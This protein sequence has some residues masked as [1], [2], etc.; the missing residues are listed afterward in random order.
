MAKISADGST[1]LYS[2]YLGG[3][4]SDV[5]NGVAVDTFGDA[6]VTGTTFSPNFPVTVDAFN[7]LCGG[8]G[9]CGTTYNPQ[10][11]VVSN[12]FV[13]KLNPAGTGLIYSS[14]LGE[15]ENV[16]GQ[17]IAVDN[18]EIA[19]VT[20][21]ADPNFAPTVPIV[22]PAV[23]PPPFPIAVGIPNGTWRW[24]RCFCDQNQRDR[25]FNPILEL[26]WGRWGRYRVRYSRRRLWGCLCYGTYLFAE[27]PHCCSAPGS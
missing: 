21:Q 12:A 19:Y 3:A 14:F 23:P 1:L 6:Y 27:F 2:T 25:H 8:D 13:S 10:G 22:L 17:A 18:D 11:F 16:R 9:K 24:H 4:A 20:G 7:T 26:S 15:Y 5:A